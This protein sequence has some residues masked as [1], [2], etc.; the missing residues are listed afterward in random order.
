MG[1]G[2]G[3]AVRR[4]WEVNTINP[5]SSE[6]V[7]EKEKRLSDITEEYVIPRTAQAS[8]WRPEVLV[9]VEPG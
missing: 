7:R 9:W 8:P 5:V 3:S 4:T 1:G 2:G 6:G